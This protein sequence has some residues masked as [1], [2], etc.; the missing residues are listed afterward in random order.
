MCHP[1]IL[2]VRTWSKL[3]KHGERRE[4]GKERKHQPDILKHSIY[5]LKH[6][7][8]DSKHCF[9]QPDYSKHSFSDIH[10]DSCKIKT[11]VLGEHDS[12]SAQGGRTSSKM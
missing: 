9:C 2:D 1:A 7:I 8:H 10:G 11:S 5:D 4:H 6:S 3:G 12:G